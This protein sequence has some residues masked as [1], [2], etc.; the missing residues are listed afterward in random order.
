LSSTLCY[1]THARFTSISSVRRGGSS[2]DSA[3]PIALPRVL[4]SPR[5]PVA[6]AERFYK[7]LRRGGVAP[8]SGLAWR[9]GEWVKAEGALK[10]CVNGIHVCRLGDLP[11]WLSDELWE[12]DVLGDRVPAA[13]TLVVARARLRERVGGW[14]KPIARALANECVWRVRELAVRELTRLKQPEADELASCSSVRDLG[15]VSGRALRRRRE[16]PAAALEFIGFAVDAAEFASKGPTTAARYVSYVA[17]HAAE[18]A[19]PEQRL[20]PGES[21]FALERER[22]AAVLQE[23]GL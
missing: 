12:V 16:R 14:P 10:P 17:A 7:F 20:R 22:Q 9:V 3:R 2:R 6:V 4:S 21:R 23:L 8:F 13:Q 11:Y 19:K 5:R 18:K 15:A 1:A